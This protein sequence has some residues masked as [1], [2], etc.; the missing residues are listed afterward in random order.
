MIQGQHQRAGLDYGDTFSPVASAVCVRLVLSLTV[1]LGWE[2]SH[3]DV[4][5]A[6]LYSPI[7]EELYMHPPIG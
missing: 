2:S 6:F 5:T 4:R 3:V 1:H 7:Q